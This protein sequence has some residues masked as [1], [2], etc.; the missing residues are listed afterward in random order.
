MVRWRGHNGG[1]DGDPAR[2]E[3]QARSLFIRYFEQHDS[4]ALDQAI[5]LFEQAA[6]G[7]TSHDPRR[8]VR[9]ALLGEALRSRY[10]LAPRRDD[11]SRAVAAGEEAVSAADL[12]VSGSSD[13]LRALAYT[14]LAGYEV[15]R[16]LEDLDAA[17]DTF[18]RAL[19]VSVQGSPAQ[20]DLMTDLVEVGCRRY[21]VTQDPLDLQEAVETANRASRR[22]TGRNSWDLRALVAAAVAHGMRYD[23]FRMTEDLLQQVSALRA[24]VDIAERGTQERVDVLIQLGAALRHEADAKDQAVL[25]TDGAA[26]AEALP[27]TWADAIEA[28]E[29]ATNEAKAIV[30]QGRT[31]ATPGSPRAKEE[32]RLLARALDSLANGY[33]TRP[34]NGAAEADLR[35]AVD[36]TTEARGL[37]D[38]DDPEWGIATNN[39]A[40][41]RR[42]LYLLD[43]DS[44]HLDAAIEI[45]RE[46]AER[47]RGDLRKILPSLAT[48]LRH[49]A[50][51]RASSGKNTAAGRL[52]AEALLEAE[53]YY[54]R[55][56]VLIEEHL[57]GLPI[58]QR[59]QE[60]A[61]RERLLQHQVGVLLDLGRARDALIAAESGKAGLLGYALRRL[62]LHAPPGVADELI[63]QE[64]QVMDDLDLQDA[65]ELAAETAPHR[66]LLVGDMAVRITEEPGL[67]LVHADSSVRAKMSL[68]R[69]R[70]QE[71]AELWARIGAAG[72]RGRHYADFRRGA[73]LAWPDLQA[74]A[75]QLDAAVVVAVP[76][77]RASAESLDGNVELVLLT[78]AA[79]SQDPAVTWTGITGELVEDLRGRIGRELARYDPA[80]PRHET[81]HR[82]LRPALQAAAQ[83]VPPVR[84]LLVSAT[85]F[86]PALPWTTLAE[87]SAWL[88]QAG[89][90]LPVTT[91]PAVAVLSERPPRTALR[92]PRVTV[93]SHPADNLPHA[94]EEAAAVV[95]VWGADLVPDEEVTREAGLRSLVDSDVVHFACHGYYRADNPLQ[96]AIRL[97][98]DDLRAADLMDR[99]TGVELLVLSACETGVAMALPGDEAVGLAA[100]FL[101]AG[102][103]TLVVSLWPVEDESTSVLMR[104]FH[105]WVRQG[106][107]LDVALRAAAADVAADSRWS[108]PYFWGSFVLIGDPS[109]L[110]NAEPS[111]VATQ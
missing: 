33:A 1:S 107:A 10:F 40:V 13:L 56:R 29:M 17:K 77:H 86:V 30:G 87:H 19:A 69:A 60:E 62:P 41:D 85:M 3:D 110:T 74:V 103:R 4:A 96:S 43:G 20:L 22:A 55:A 58:S 26:A 97:V 78:Y 111:N 44:T 102:V 8:A 53:A 88:S 64:R 32:S 18:G 23:L 94:A 57:S 7:S 72:E 14:H 54:R 36:L 47:G 71:L 12:S 49:R 106:W 82:R 84:R 28:L 104:G 50:A 42:D 15:E 93:L 76:A 89:E 21:E 61:F 90:P 91:V 108:H 45:W 109:P 80:A 73:E 95:R 83:T 100:A 24:A 66:S 27:G 25:G 67:G 38:A 35:R 51:V 6:A 52:D 9:L 11:L 99:H 31:G 16:R 70:Q 92:A 105:A 101:R 5:A 59:L 34:H 98:D 68:R 2:A 37:V 48:A 79:S 75:T 63:V 65:M 81:W 46:A 39:L